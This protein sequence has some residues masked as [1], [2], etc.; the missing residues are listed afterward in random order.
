MAERRRRT[1]SGDKGEASV[2]EAESTPMDRFKALARRLLNVPRNEL[3]AEQRKHAER[4]EK[5][6]GAEAPRR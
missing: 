4:Q 2:A 5:K 1:E 6:R 3:A